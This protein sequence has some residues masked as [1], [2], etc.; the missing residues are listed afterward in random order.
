[1]VVVLLA[2]LLLTSCTSEERARPSIVLFVYDTLRYDATTPYGAPAEVTPALARLARNGIVYENAY[3][4]APWTLP[5]HVS[6][7]SGLLPSQHGAGVRSV[8]T[9]DELEM[10]AEVLSD[11]GYQTRGIIENA[12]LGEEFNVMQ[13]FERTISLPHRSPPKMFDAA[14]QEAL[15]DRD[16]TRPLFL[17][18]NVMDAHG[19]YQAL[20]H[21]RFVPPSTSPADATAA[22][23]AFQGAFCSRSE[24]IWKWRP[25]WWQ[26]Y[27]S[28]VRGADDKLARVLDHLGSERHPLVT[29]ATADHG[30]AL[31]EHYLTSH[32]YSLRQQVI[33]IPLVVQGRN[34]RPA[35]I[36]TPVGL[37]NVH[38][39]ILDW[40]GVKE[41][42][43]STAP[44]PLTR[45]D[46]ADD[47]VISEYFDTGKGPIV[48]QSWM[49]RMI[50]LVRRGCRKSDRVRGDMRTVIR[51]S[52]KLITYTEYPT[53]LFDLET[54]P[55]EQNDLAAD[56]LDLVAELEKYL[57]RR[58]KG[59]VVETS[60]KIDLS[61][62]TIER[63]R[64][65]GYTAPD[66]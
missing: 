21:G 12:W 24:E 55:L 10:L 17:F 52:M 51:K 35:R 20:R 33:H 58:R 26:M 63:L 48:K 29:V 6:L 66:E 43:G 16:P 50:N 7:F 25:L 2:A 53:E 15:A 3:A 64:A 46:P 30:Q 5:S 14:V 62:E 37:L 42:A 4:P 1:M 40:A 45:D 65:L 41:R 19:P 13:G 32:I 9:A 34:A 54:D 47:A 56:R 61:P 18:V 44:L 57:D 28:G 49:L 22:V 59:P 38:A 23:G 60:E 39:S 27:L 36:E 11:A 8:H 31:G